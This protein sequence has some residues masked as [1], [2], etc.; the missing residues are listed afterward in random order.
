MSSINLVVLLGNI[1]ADPELRY[2]QNGTAV[3]TMRMATTKKWTDK[4]NNA[5]EKT[6]WHTVVAWAKQAEWLID[7][8]RKG[9]QVLVFGYLQTRSWEDPKLLDPDGKP[10]KRYATEVVATAWDRFGG[11]IGT[12][13]EKPRNPN[14]G[15]KHTDSDHPGAPNKRKPPP[16][17][18]G[19][20]KTLGPPPHEGD[21]IPADPGDD[22][23]P[24]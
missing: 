8:K 21:Y 4:D 17:T 2:T 15:P 3:A 23:I 10:F 12:Y 22:D 9:D 20:E 11:I 5:C 7:N 18:V 14:A 1:G 19:G 24:F 13:G 6:E 16:G